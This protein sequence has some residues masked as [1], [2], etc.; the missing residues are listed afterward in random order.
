MTRP[1]SMSARTA[2][3]QEPSP[4]PA[5]APVQ[6][7]GEA[8]ESGDR[9]I[10]NHRRFALVDVTFDDAP[11][12]GATV[13]VWRDARG[14]DCWCVRVLMPSR[15]VP[16]EGRIAGRLRDGRLIRG[17]M[18]LVSTG[19]A[20]RGKAPILV[21]WRGLDALTVDDAADRA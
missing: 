3:A 10:R 17:R 6:P 20:P 7:T 18:G 8:P 5:P 12:G 11:V 21:E 15:D 9:V 2:H 13:D 14:A 1:A 4:P 19:H 16:A